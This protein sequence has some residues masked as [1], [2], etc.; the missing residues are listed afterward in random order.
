[1]EDEPKGGVYAIHRKWEKQLFEE[2]F[3]E[4]ILESTM[5]LLT[6]GTSITQIGR[7]G[8][9]ISIDARNFFERNEDV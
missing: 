2:I 5:D 4:I 3:K 7:N 8:E 9:V 1:M 6:Y